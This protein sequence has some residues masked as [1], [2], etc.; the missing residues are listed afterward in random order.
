[1]SPYFVR[2]VIIYMSSYSVRPVIIRA[3]DGTGCLAFEEW[4]EACMTIL[5]RYSH[6]R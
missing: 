3:H 4:D 6:H 1:M 2:P 5:Q